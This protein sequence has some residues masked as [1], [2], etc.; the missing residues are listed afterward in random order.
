MM[1][2]GFSGSPPAFFWQKNKYDDEINFGLKPGFKLCLKPCFCYHG[3]KAVTTA[4][5][6]G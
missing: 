4:V 2:F 6:S 1:S 3:N 5:P